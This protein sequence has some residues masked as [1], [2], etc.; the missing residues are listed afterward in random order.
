MTPG[1]IQV[2]P[3]T[4]GAQPQTGSAICPT[5]DP[6]VL[7]GQYGR[8]R[9]S[10]NSNETTLA[11]FNSTTAS[12]FGL[13]AFY[14][15]TS[16]PPGTF[17]YEPVVAQPLYATNVITA[18]GSKISMLV[19]ATLNDYVYAYDTSDGTQVWYQNL[20]NDCGLGTGT[21]FDNSH[22]HSPGGANLDYYGI[23]ATPVIDTV[24]SSPIAFA[25][26]ACTPSWGSAAISWYLNALD[27]QNGKVFA[28]QLLTDASFNG[29]YQV[30]RPSLLLSHPTS[31]TSDLYIAF[32]TG[33]GELQAAGSCGSNCAYT[34]VLFGYSVAYHSTMPYV[35]FSAL[36]PSPFYTTCATNPNPATACATNG[37]F[38]SVNTSFSYGASDA[39]TGPN[40]VTS[41]S[42]VCDGGDNWF[43]GGGIW[44]S[45]KG[46]ASTASASVYL[47]SGN[48]AFA[49]TT[50]ATSCTAASGANGVSYWGESAMKFPSATA[51]NPMKPVDFFAPYPQRYTTNK[52]G[53]DPFPATY[54]TEELSRMDL[55]FGSSGVVIIPH[56]TA[57]AM[58]ADKSGYLYVM[59][60][61][62]NSLG[63]FQGGD[64]GLTGGTVTTQLPFQISRYPYGT[65]QG[66]CPIN[67]DS[68]DWTYTTTSCD[69]VHEL[70]FWADN[71]L[72]FVWPVNESVEVFQGS[73]S[74][75]SYSF[76]TGPAF[77]PCLTAGNC[78]GEAPL[79]PRSQPN[80]EGGV[81]ALAVDGSDAGTLWGRVPRQNAATPPSYVW[82]W[83]YAYSIATDGTLTHIW[84][85]GTGHNCSSPPATGWFTTSFTEPTLANGA[86]Y[87]PSL[88]AVTDGN[89]YQY[90]G[91]VPTGAVASG[92]L[93]FGT[94]GS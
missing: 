39:P 14:A 50:T 81:M 18:G 8:Y 89:Q 30:A 1:S 67:T 34:G 64:S 31:T 77:D 28:T 16:T 21:P 38:P 37:L 40:C 88:C 2:G 69:E 58:N 90:C 91:A 26:S 59:P 56:T 49:C 61:E 19:V 25:V 23:V 62:A 3:S 47:A 55:D 46:P 78:T 35:T 7:T 52:T 85:S 68:P 11:N 93:V 10:T 84:D 36:G 76:G 15:F 79:F 41:G 12:S 53:G 80:S 70:A 24:P 48:G 43:N 83:L 74:S 86:A 94:C 87:V 60:A 72:L 27:I 71:D 75:T 57:F 51:S 22:G 9:T 54:Q 29:P 32:G 82:G 63:L 42:G 92:I 20:A 5:G 13:A 73:Y 33:V 17:T 44:M 6:C 66:A 65:N 45:S 4:P